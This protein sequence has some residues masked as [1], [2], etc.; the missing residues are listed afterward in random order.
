VDGAAPVPISVAGGGAGPAPAPNG[1]GGGGSLVPVAADGVTGNGAMPIA[2]LPP[3]ALPAAAPVEGAARAV[4]AFAAVTVARDD[5][6]PSVFGKI[7]AADS[8]RVALV[9]PRGNRDLARRLGMRR[10]QRHL[11][12]TGKDLILVTRA[13]VLRVRA[14]EEGVPCVTS[15]RRVNFDRRGSG[16][17]QLGWVTLR[18]PTLGTFLAVALFVLAVVAGA[19]VLFWYVPTATVTVF[20]PTET[21]AESIDIVVGAK[22]TEID[23]ARG[24]V[25]ARRREVMLQRALPG[26]ATGVGAIPVE[27]AAV[28][29][30]FTN[31][32]NQPIY[33][34]KGTVVT[35]A[36]GMSFTVGNDVNLPG[37]V[38]AGGEAIALAQRP[39]T[40]GNVPAR[41]ITKVE[42]PLADRVAV[43]NPAPGEKGADIPQTV[44]SEQD[45]QFLRE[46]ATAYFADAAKKELLAQFA[47]SETVF[48]DSARVELSDCTPVPPVGQ[49]AR[50][51]ELAC[52]ARVSML[53][54]ADAD[55]HRIWRDRFLARLDADK[56]VL[57]GYF[58]ATV[59]R[60]GEPDATFDRL[61]VRMRVTVPVAPLTDR[62]ALRR[63][64]AGKSRAGVEQVLRR[65]VA[66]PVPPQVELPG[67]APWLPRWPDRIRV[68]FKPAP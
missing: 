8:P 25:P 41:S 51:T 9:A 23:V 21:A 67:W 36:N 66:T 45:V 55:L 26:P 22:V 12:L 50:Y 48:G 61:P 2:I 63:A 53:T 18:L 52:T 29:V 3:A 62:N 38:G 42:G 32:T 4:P 34:P 58:K 24:I 57:D 39:G 13:R 59:E 31:R 16:G 20:L 5:D 47:S 14:R 27:H 19:A 64:L 10:L 44:V 30:I 11:D 17:L 40:A 33:V 28:G 68:V 7:D 65:Q 54:V 35:A 1:S 43:I 56:M 49:A 46:L 6:L 37:R 60:V 15:L